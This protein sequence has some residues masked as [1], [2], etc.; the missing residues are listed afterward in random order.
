MSSGGRIISSEVEWGL[1][2]YD[3]EDALSDIQPL[4]KELQSFLPEGVVS[5]EQYLSNGGSLLIDFGYHPEYSAAEFD[6]VEEATAGEMAGEVVTNHSL[7]GFVAANPKL[8]SFRQNKRVR[9]H[10]GNTWGYH[11]NYGAQAGKIR[12][13]EDVLG[14]LALHFATRNIYAGAGFVDQYPDDEPV[15]R[16]AQKQLNLNV[17][18]SAATTGEDHKAVVNLRNQAHADNKRFLRLHM[19]SGDAHMSPWAMRMTFGTTSLV[20]KMI[21]RGY[22]LDHLEPRFMYA[23]LA[24]MV[25]RDLTLAEKYTTVT[26]ESILPVDAQEALVEIGELLDDDGLL[27]EE[28]QWVLKEWRYTVDT[29]RSNPR[30]LS[31]RCEWM[32]KQDFVE[33]HIGRLR[34]EAPQTKHALAAARHIDMLWD[35]FSEDGIGLKLRSSIWKPWMPRQETID[36]LVTN[37]PASTRARV[38]GLIVKNH[39]E[40]ISKMSWDR[41]EFDSATIQLPNPY[42]SELGSLV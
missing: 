38:R 10:I 16:V 21:E 31:D 4:S 40:S 17:D 30:S 20:I 26:G 11:E 28:E 33:K 7:S 22:E 23:N 32:L 3:N 12:I 5:H 9:D 2:L 14:T 6:S 8:S 36:H 18:F 25:A 13:A 1:R 37:P 19:T 35:E 41:V 15:F 42:Q 39:T 29:L 24:K 27:N 34:Q